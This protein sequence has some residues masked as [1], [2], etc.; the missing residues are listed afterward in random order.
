MKK[1]MVK[2]LVAGLLLLPS[3]ACA[4]FITGN[5]LLSD[6]QSTDNMRRTFA[7]GYVAGVAD[8]HHSV[9][10]CPPSGINL[11][12][13]RD[14]TEQYLIINASTRNLSADV[15]IGDMLNRRWPCKT[16]PSGRGA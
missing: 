5:Q 7:M 13:L 1:F 11:G 15:L 6:I 4:E 10:Y 16:P 12:Q 8:A 2:K 3:L 9:T 14:M